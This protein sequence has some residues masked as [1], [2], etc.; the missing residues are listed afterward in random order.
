MTVLGILADTTHVRAGGDLYIPTRVAAQLDRLG[1]LFDGVVA[2]APLVGGEPPADFGPYLR[3]RVRLDELREAGGPALA[4]KARVLVRAIGWVPALRRTARAADLVHF[5][6]P[7]NVTLVALLVVPRSKPWYAMYAGSWVR[8]AGEPWSYRLQRWLLRRRRNGVVTAYVPTA[9]VA[10]G[11]G[12]SDHVVPFY[13]PTHTR[14]ELVD[15][16]AAARPKVDALL[17]G[18][19]PSP[20]RAVCVGYLSPHKNHAIAIHAVMEAR[21]QGC[22]VE[23]DVAGDGQAR[24]QLRRLVDR[25]GAGDAVRLH[26]M[27]PHDEVRRLNRDAHV[28]ILLSS[29]E[30]QP[31]AVLEGMAAGAV[32]VLSPFA[33][34]LDITGRGSR[35]VVVDPPDAATAAA[36]LIALAGDP[37]RLG[38]MAAEC[39]RYT[40]RYSLEAFE[41]D[42]AALLTRRWPDLFSS[43][44]RPRS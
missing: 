25:L 13:S 11:T 18:L 41:E 3:G 22:D 12:E 8:Y 37:I 1:A 4:D 43:A 44:D 39:L 42:L 35:G 27:L 33:L 40:A 6:C 28:T 2:C 23:L 26:G 36:A 9:S 38:R 20:L 14:S 29:V 17:A 16:A 24:D 31:K 5:R 32:P 21:R 19:R 34:A 15:D 10:N 30:G 7:C